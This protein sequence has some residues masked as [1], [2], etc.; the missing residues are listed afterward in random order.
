MFHV[1]HEME[2]YSIFIYVSR[3]TFFNLI[4]LGCEK[5]RIKYDIGDLHKWEKKAVTCS[6]VSIF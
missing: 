1:K 3:E 5:I 4:R 2:E 6:N